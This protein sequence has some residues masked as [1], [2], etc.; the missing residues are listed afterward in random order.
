MSA[1]TAPDEGNG[2]LAVT[3]SANWP[4][5]DERPIQV[6]LWSPPSGSAPRAPAGE[7]RWIVLLI[8]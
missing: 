6:V 2:H 4:E 5:P 3:A 8:E 7:E 1:A